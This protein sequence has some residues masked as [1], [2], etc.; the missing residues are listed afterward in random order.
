VVLKLVVNK[1][2]NIPRNGIKIGDQKSKDFQKM[3]LM[4]V[5]TK[6]QNTFK[7]GIKID[8]KRKHFQNIAL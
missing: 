8:H 2:Q 7:N 4:L 1:G 5:V 6:G 3:A